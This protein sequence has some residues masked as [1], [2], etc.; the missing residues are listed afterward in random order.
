MVGAADG[1]R[2][3]SPAKE[4][5][6]PRTKKENRMVWLLDGFGVDLWVRRHGWRRVAVSEAVWERCVAIPEGVTG[7]TEDLR[8]WDFLVFLGCGLMRP[9]LTASRSALGRFEYLA[10]VVNDNR[11]ECDPAL[12]QDW[13]DPNLWLAVAAILD[14]HGSPCLVVTLPEEDALWL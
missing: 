6:Q 10:S 1:E 4:V 11:D 8:L 2:H 5:K 14:D 12:E 13:P 9:E 7:Q 3:G